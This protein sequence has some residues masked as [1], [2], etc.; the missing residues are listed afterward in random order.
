M[1][2]LYIDLSQAVVT[3]EQTQIVLFLDHDECRLL[4]LCENVTNIKSFRSHLNIVESH[5]V[6]WNCIL[7]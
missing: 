5:C 4:L 6:H 3:A 7:V 2:H 1:D